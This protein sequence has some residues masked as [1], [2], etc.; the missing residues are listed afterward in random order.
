MR[1]EPNR[2]VIFPESWRSNPVIDL[3]EDALMARGVQFARAG[4]DYLSFGWLWRQRG[5]INILHFHWLE[6][7]YRR[8][9]RTGS[10]LALA[11]FCAKVAFARI[12]RYRV[13]WSMHNLVPHERETLRLDSVGIRWMTAVANAVIVHC[14]EGRRLLAEC[15]GRS[16]RVFRAYLGH[17]VDVYPQAVERAEARDRLGI[18]RESALLLFFGAVRPYKG[19]ELLLDEFKGMPDQGLRLVIAGNPL[20]DEYAGRIRTLAALDSRVTAKLEW[21]ADEDV[22]LL[23]GAADLVVLPFTSILTSSSAI[24]A[25]SFGRAVVAPAAGCLPELIGKDCGMLY[26]PSQPGALGA[27][28]HACL[29]LDLTAMGQRALERVSQF[30]WDDLA[31]QTIAAYQATSGRQHDRRLSARVQTAEREQSA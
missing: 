25:M 17:Y 13:V 12:L 16:S 20:N 21:I 6:Y 15:Y 26:D 11:K 31:D 18:D 30:T 22:P 1:R 19:L 27:A 5:K 10:W 4:S 7:H 14:N 23:F 28:V 29:Q 3:M 9:T 8:P 24:T 2:V